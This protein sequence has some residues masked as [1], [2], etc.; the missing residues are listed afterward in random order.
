MSANTLRRLET[1]ATTEKRAQ[2]EA[3]QFA[4][5]NTGS[6]RVRNESH[7]DPSDHEYSVD[8]RADGTPT[9][10]TCPA[11][12]HYDGACKHMVAVAIR[13][14]VHDA[15]AVSDDEADDTTEDGDGDNPCVA[16]C[17]RCPGPNSADD[18]LPCFECAMRGDG[19]IRDE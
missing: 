10:C 1:D 3:F 15:A 16:D 5:E 17:E 7:A 19:V 9:A 2:Y 6:V 4:L 14:P 12:E 8:V 18:R 13:E 11:Y